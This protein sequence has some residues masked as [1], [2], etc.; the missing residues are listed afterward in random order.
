MNSIELPDFD[1]SIRRVEYN[2]ETHFSLVDV[3]AFFS[4]T[5]ADARYYWRDTKK[6]LEADG[7]QLGE[8]ISQLKL[9][10]S[11]GKSY[12]TD[13]ATGEIVM[14][15]VQ[16]IPS[17]KAEPIREWLARL[18]YERLEE[19]ANPN[20]GIDRAGERY[21]ADMQERYGLDRN[22][23]LKAA[24][25]RLQGKVTRNSMT[26]ALREYIT[27]AIYYGTFTDTEYLGLFGKRAKQMNAELGGNPRDLMTPEALNF[28]DI[29][30]G[31]CQRAMQQRGEMT[32]GEACDLMRQIAGALG[33][34][35][36]QLESITGLDLL[37][38]K[39]LLEGKAS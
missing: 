17:P 31:T 13:C 29:A 23:A 25:K 32:F 1:K 38:G 4:D 7:F 12:K 14:R 18:G 10:S 30:E 36:R 33:V 37:T 8:K 9:V 20:L 21:A 24:I 19:K 28:I 16:S 22:A 5:T 15:I 11:D 39:P 27:D 35:V 3:M 6:R 34:N 26:D 2:G